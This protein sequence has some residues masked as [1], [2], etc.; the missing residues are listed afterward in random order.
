MK[1]KICKISDIPEN[2]MKS[3]DVDGD[4]VL[5][6]KVNGELLSIAD[7]CSHALAY[8]SEGELLVEECQVQCPDH[9]AIFDLRTGEALALPAVSPV[10]TYKVTVDGDD[11]FV[12]RAE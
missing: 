6:A 4:P 7:T 8:L 2:G 11:V 12:E 5:I 9:G 1:T 3:F 10:D